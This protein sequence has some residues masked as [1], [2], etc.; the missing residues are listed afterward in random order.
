MRNL[1]NNRQKGITLIALVVTIVV[2]IILA[3]VSIL[4]VFGDNG[5]I[6]RAEESKKQTKEA[7]KKEEITLAVAAS[8]NNEGKI[9]HN[10]LKDNLNKIEGIK[11]IKKIE[12]DEEKKVEAEVEALPLVVFTDEDNVIFIAKDGTST[13]KAKPS[14]DVDMNEDGIINLVD[15]QII[16]DFVNGKYVLT[17]E[18]KAKADISG[19]GEINTW[20]AA[21]LAAYINGKIDIL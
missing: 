16:H 11:T 17:D 18:K 9:D 4:T 6:S 20:D 12:T 5:I 14:K 21:L 7:M 8:Y 19:D 2:L 3:T 10:L 13:R 1:K 15:M